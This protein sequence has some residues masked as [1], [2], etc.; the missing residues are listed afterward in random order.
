MAEKDPVI[1]IIMV[2]ESGVGKTSLLQR[3]TENAF[4][5]SPE[6]S[7]GMDFKMKEVTVEG[8]RVR[9]QLWDTAGQERFR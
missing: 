9:L 5:E 1:K 2:G 8:R 7:L 4:S 3:Y 6:S